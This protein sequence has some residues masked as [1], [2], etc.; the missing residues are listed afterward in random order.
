[1]V[2]RVMFYVIVLLSNAAMFS[3]PHI[4]ENRTV[5]L[6]GGFESPNAFI[7]YIVMDA[8]RY[9]VKQKK[10]EKEVNFLVL[11]K[12]KTIKK[13]KKNAYATGNVN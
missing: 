9:I 7:S 6:E 8:V 12:T 11:K 1:M 4:S 5:F 13:N 3:S 2:T 10:S